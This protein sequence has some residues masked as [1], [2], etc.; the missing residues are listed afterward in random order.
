MGRAGLYRHHVNPKG[1][2]YDIDRFGMIVSTN[3]EGSDAD[4]T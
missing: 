3:E 2:S 1:E 4:P